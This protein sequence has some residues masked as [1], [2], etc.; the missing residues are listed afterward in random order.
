M[1]A[2]FIIKEHCAIAEGLTVHTGNHPRVIGKF[3]TDI[4]EYN[5]PKGYDK[6]V[7]IEEDVWIGCNV[8]ILTG[9]IIGRGVTVAA[10]AVVN[11]SIPPYCI[12]G[13][14]PAKFIKFYWTIDQILEHEV[15]LYPEHERYTKEQLETL[16]RKYNK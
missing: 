16:F 7:I 5:K 12:C 11:K 15:K 13:G 3:I 4:T 8:T 6:D 1:N 2:K 10:N 14:I 9:V